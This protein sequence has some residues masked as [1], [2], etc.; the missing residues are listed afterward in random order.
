MIRFKMADLSEFKDPESAKMPS[1]DASGHGEL[2]E[3]ILLASG[4]VQELD[5]NFSLFNMCAVAIV[6]GNCWA[7]TGST[8]VSSIPEA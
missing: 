1:D 4:H 8:I 3:E 6:I 7:I 2:K 5:R